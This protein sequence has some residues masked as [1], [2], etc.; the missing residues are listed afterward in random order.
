[1]FFTRLISGVVLVL[2]ALVTIISGDIVLLVTLL[3]T[4]LAGLFELY[5]A[6]KV[7]EKGFSVLAAVGYAGTL[8]YYLMLLLG[9]EAYS[10]I[11]LIFL[12]AAF[13]SVYVFTFPKYRSEQVMSAFFGVVYVS[14]MLSYIY[15]TRMM[16]D[17]AFER[18]ENG[19]FQQI[20]DWKPDEDE[21]GLFEHFFASWLMWVCQIVIG[22]G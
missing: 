8:L 7:Q 2:A 16:E 11:G 21:E 4:S 15:Q 14:V 5:R 10:M 1:M 13:M 22:A 20:K 17:G 9:L 19:V 3:L 6:V 12:L 18:D